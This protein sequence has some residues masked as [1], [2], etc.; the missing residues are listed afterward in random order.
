MNEEND[1][2]LKG[3]AGSGEEGGGPL[4]AIFRP[5][6]APAPVPA[7]P[8]APPAPIPPEKPPPPPSQDR[9]IIDY[10]KARM[11]EMESK[12]RESQEKGLAFA[13]E[14]KGREEARKESR[15]EMEEFLAAVKRQQAESETER[16]RGLELEKA[17]ARIEAL[18]FK[19]MEL[20]VPRAEAPPPHAPAGGIEKLQAGLKAELSA[21]FELHGAKLAD[22]FKKETLEPLAARLDA[23]SARDLEELVKLRISLKKEISE[24]FELLG[25]KLTEKILAEAVGP[26]AGRLEAE[27][28]AR[29]KDLCDMRLLSD[30][31]AGKVSRL[32]NAFSEKLSDMETLYAGFSSQMAAAVQAA[33][34][35][36]E[37]LRVLSVTSFKGIEKVEAAMADEFGK[38]V[39][40]GEE[41]RSSLRDV[42][43]GMEASRKETLGIVEDLKRALAA[44]GAQAADS[45]AGRLVSNSAPYELGFI[46]ACF[47]N[48]EKA[49]CAAYE[50]LA[51]TSADARKSAGSPG[52]DAAFIAH[53]QTAFLDSATRDLG[54]ALEVFRGVKQEALKPIKK[55]LGA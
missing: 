19:I 16:S 36:N 55:V 20:S 53:R 1:K 27:N 38:M 13:Y 23:E 40:S 28:A 18:E 29:E 14:L 2:S 32:E 45:A 30:S 33:E 35:N 7:P 37:E 22:K 25:G 21:D 10:L 6:P 41:F 11:T 48:L 5:A 49:F 9:E 17:R 51:R 3:L 47:D 15:R 46:T 31:I 8:P 24:G 34:K 39:S 54:L 50:T 12:L 26:L 52:A 42:S 4:F 43:A 44:G